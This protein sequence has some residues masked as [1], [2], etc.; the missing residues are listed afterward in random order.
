MPATTHNWSGGAASKDKRQLILLVGLSVVLLI[1]LVWQ[2]PKLLGGSSSESTPVASS[3]VTPAA[4]PATTAAPVRTTASATTPAADRTVVWIKSLPSRDPFVPL[5]GDEPAAAPAATPAATPASAEPVIVTVA[6]PAAPSAG[7]TAA[8]AP[9][10]AVVYTNGQKQV[11]G[12]GE[13]FKV[14]DLWFRLK[15][16]KPKLMKIEL[17]DAGFTGGGDAI[18]VDRNHPVT[19]ANTATGVEYT[20]RFARATSGIATTSQ[21]EPIEASETTATEPTT[22]TPTSTTES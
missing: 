17:V 4:A 18:T 7:E 11:V 6:E 12:V 19:L 21:T 16:V 20:L 5:A 15:A 22:A 3:E 14:R 9:N 2:V 1:L 13:Y 8:T 10:I